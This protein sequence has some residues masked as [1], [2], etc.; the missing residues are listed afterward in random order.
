MESAFLVFF[1]F[2]ELFPC[3]ISTQRTS[4]A[5]WSFI[6]FL[7]LLLPQLVLQTRLCAQEWWQGLL[8]PSQGSLWTLTACEFYW[9]PWK[10]HQ[11]TSWTLEISKERP[12]HYV[13]WLTRNFLLV[14]LCFFLKHLIHLSRG[15]LHF[16]YGN[17]RFMLSFIQQA[18]THCI[19]W[20]FVFWHICTCW[21]QQVENCQ[22]LS[23]HGMWNNL[24]F[25]SRNA[26]KKWK[27][28][29]PV[30]KQ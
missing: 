11:H 17:K 28:Y 13:Q 5:K 8:P 30:K 20:R 2:H 23:R 26:Y 7:C 6:D 18:N 27:N 22:S 3:I 15:G 19:F 16:L 12:I 10:D 9:S 14:Y 29:I 1:L 4:G 21:K 24:S 25:H